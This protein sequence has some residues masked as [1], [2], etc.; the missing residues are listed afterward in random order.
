MRK[1]YQKKRRGTNNRTEKKIVLIAT[2]GNN[3]TEEQYFIKFNSK[4]TQVKFTSGNATDPVN[5]ANQLVKEYE[6]EELNRELGDL[7]FCVVDGDVSAEREEQIFKADS[8]V[9]KVGEVVVSNP[10]I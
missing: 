2:E 1:A 8:I 6:A 4:D 5:M 3:K 10:C 9:G 7:A